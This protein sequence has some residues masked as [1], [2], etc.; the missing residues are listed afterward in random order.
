MQ[1]SFSRRSFLAALALTGAS[2]ALAAASVQRRPNILFLYTDDQTFDSIRALGNSEIQT[3]NMDRLA[4]RGTAFM[5]CYN[6]GGWHGAICV[7]SRTMLNTGLFLWQ[8]APLEKK[9]AAIAKQPFLSKALHSGGYRTLF[10]GKWHVPGVAPKAVFDEAR[11]VRGAMPASGEAAYNRPR[12]GKTDLWS[13]YDTKRGGHW[14]GGTHWSAVTAN[15]AID[16]LKEAPADK[17]F[18]IYAGFNAPHDPRQSPKEY[19][20]LYP[21]EKVALPPNFQPEHP[22]NEA[23][24]APRSLRDE[25]LAPFPRT[26][27]SVQVH[28]G[29]YYALITYLDAQLGRVLDALEASGKANETIVVLCG[30]NG[31]SVGQHGLMGKQN[32]YEHS[33]K[34][35]LIIAGPGIPEGRRVEQPVYLQDIR[36]TL[37][38]YARID[39]PD[40][41]DAAFKPLTPLLQAAP[42]KEAFRP[43]TYGAYM[44]SQRMIREGDWKLIWYAGGEKGRYLLFNL[45]NDPH[46][47]TNLAETPKHAATVKKLTAALR[48]E[49]K[50]VGDPMQLPE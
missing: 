20:D 46:E 26:P 6:P 7:A 44:H 47:I 29:E 36:P 24:G 28:R 23:M 16:Y 18:F 12:E 49:M 39:S 21:P 42:A 43:V 35:P 11:H 22:G 37:F 25:R 19:V 32:M 38:A 30:D 14:Q 8:A 48:A 45:A 34:V 40:G 10:T 31:L 4:A 15:D 33:L 2:H 1:P 3:P 27:H 9:S 5:N 50:R 17:P 41:A 13:P